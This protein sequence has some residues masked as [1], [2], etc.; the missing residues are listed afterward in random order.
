MKLSAIVAVSANGVIGADNQIPWY[1]PDDLK[2]FKRVTLG[3]P[4]L[5][6][7]KC[8]ASIGRPLPKR[9]NVVLTRNAFYVADGVTVAHSPEQALEV[10]RHSGA[11]T[12]FVIGGADIYELFWA[13]TQT[14]YL[15][16]VH[17]EFEGATAERAIDHRAPFD[18]FDPLGPGRRSIISTTACSGQLTQF[19]RF[20]S[21]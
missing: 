3:H 10:A 4:V 15:T 9:L 21:S 16:R 6:G 5:M 2:Y 20:A 7:R 19:G 8:F 18:R 1:L 12:A 13:Q 11:E 17:A 14:L